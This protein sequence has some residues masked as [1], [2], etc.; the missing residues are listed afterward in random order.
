[1]SVRSKTDAS[2]LPNAFHRTAPLEAI[3]FCI[4]IEP[5]PGAMIHVL[6]P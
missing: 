4:S 3:E 1:M 5:Q 2:D 6:V